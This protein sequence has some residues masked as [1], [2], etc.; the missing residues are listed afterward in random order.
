AW[1][2][3]DAPTAGAAPGEPPPEA[4]ADP[5][6]MGL[7]NELSELDKKAPDAGATP[8]AAL[9]KHHLARTDLLEKIAADAKPDQRDPW[10]R[11]IAD[12]LSTAAQNSAPDDK[13]A[14]NRLVRLEESTAK[15]APGGSLAGYVAYRELQADY[16]LRLAA[17]KPDIAKVQQ[18]WV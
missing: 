2:L 17:P 8:S 10:V 13:A 11:Q 1:R 5:K 16:A 3:T 7:I 4:Q 15:S 14:M 12:S 9:A 18:E 6:L